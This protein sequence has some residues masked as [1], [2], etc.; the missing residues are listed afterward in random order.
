[1]R[2]DN[3]RKNLKQRFKNRQ[4]RI[5]FPE[6]SSQPRRKMLQRRNALQGVTD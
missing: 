4:L 6:P 5:G 2:I 3:L 1:L